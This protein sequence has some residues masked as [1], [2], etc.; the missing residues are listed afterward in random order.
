MP[1]KRNLLVLLF[2]VLFAVIAGLFIMMTSSYFNT[3]EIDLLVSGCY[4]NGG[5]VM[6][7]IHNT[8]TSSY[9]FECER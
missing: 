6:L 2:V 8:L 3:K 1:I 4:E 7:E 5:K 9:S